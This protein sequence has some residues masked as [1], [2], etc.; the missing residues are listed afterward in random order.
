MLSWHFVEK[1]KSALFS[2]PPG[3]QPNRQTEIS[4][5]RPNSIVFVAD[6]ENVS[7]CRPPDKLPRAPRA[8]SGFHV[9]AVVSVSISE[10]AQT[11]S[12]NH[13]DHRRAT[14]MACWRIQGD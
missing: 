3:I 1:M 13:A 11:A 12:G 14:A 9:I 8:W 6:A 4:T 7:D 5:V 2:A 10:P